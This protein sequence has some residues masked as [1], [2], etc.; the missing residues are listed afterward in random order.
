MNPTRPAE[1][2]NLIFWL[3]EY[4]ITATLVFFSL[5][6]AIVPE[7]ANSRAVIVPLVPAAPLLILHAI[8]RRAARS[9][10]DRKQ[11]FNE[12]MWYAFESSALCALS[13]VLTHAFVLSYLGF[14]LQNTRYQIALMFDL[15]GVIAVVVA[16]AVAT[17]L[18]MNPKSKSTGL[19]HNTY[20]GI[21][22][23]VPVQLFIM[24]RHATAVIREE[25]GTAWAL[26]Q[27]LVLAAIVS[28]NIFRVSRKQV[29][30]HTESN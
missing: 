29:N 7:L 26:T 1:A 16:G 6:G 11:S 17:P 22:I 5:V 19:H 12:F 25:S 9:T 2:T 30:S 23:A 24:E 8:S 13:I 20:I 18:L 15:P 10:R 4:I 28:L 27:A 21:W 3:A 14:S